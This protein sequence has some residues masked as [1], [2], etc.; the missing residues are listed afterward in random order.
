MS[1]DKISAPHLLGKCHTARIPTNS[2]RPGSNV[3][4]SGM[5]SLNSHITGSIHLPS[6]PSTKFITP[7]SEC[8]A[9]YSKVTLRLI[10]VSPCKILSSM[11]AGTC[12]SFTKCTQCLVRWLIL[13]LHDWAI[14]CPDICSSVITYVSVRAFLDEFN[15]YISGLSRADC[16]P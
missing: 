6:P 16:P 10:C 2:L 12:V 14:G 4:T 7:S 13:C 5:P 9:Q 3:T 15:I 8:Q 1:R 11:R